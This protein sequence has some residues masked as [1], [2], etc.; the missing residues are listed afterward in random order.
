[1]AL[2]FL[3]GGIKLSLKVGDNYVLA[4]TKN[5]EFLRLCLRRIK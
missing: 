1:L 3:K 2:F 4:R 5:F